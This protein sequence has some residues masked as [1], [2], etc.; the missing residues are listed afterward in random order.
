M[1]GYCDQRLA[2]LLVFCHW[3][4]ARA[5]GAAKP[6]QAGQAEAGRV[7]CRLS[8]ANH[9][10]QADIFQCFRKLLN[11]AKVESGVGVE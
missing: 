10:I 4:I 1:D 9:D 8:L 11:R 7:E 5:K 6:I 2:V 3:Q